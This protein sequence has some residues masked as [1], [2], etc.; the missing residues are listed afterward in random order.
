MLDD[1]VSDSS[2]N[3]LLKHMFDLT[4]SNHDAKNFET[5][6]WRFSLVRRPMFYQRIGLPLFIKCF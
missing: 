5:F 1:H 2:F 4:T 6:P 3:C